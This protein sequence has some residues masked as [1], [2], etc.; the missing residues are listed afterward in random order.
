MIAA[1]GRQLKQSVNVFHN[2]ILNLRLP[3]NYNKERDDSLGCESS[4]LKIRCD[5]FEANQ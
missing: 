1:I 2:F 4:H 5:S 3:K